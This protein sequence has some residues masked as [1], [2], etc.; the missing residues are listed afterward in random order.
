MLAMGIPILRVLRGQRGIADDQQVL[1]VL[2]LRRL[3]EVLLYA[4][5]DKTFRL[6]FGEAVCCSPMTGTSWNV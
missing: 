5:F 1:G 3:G 6:D 4:A 2:F